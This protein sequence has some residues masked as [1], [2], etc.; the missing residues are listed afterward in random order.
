MPEIQI[1]L[2]KGQGKSPK[3]ADYVDLLP[4]NIVPIVGDAEGA[5]G[6]FRFWP[7]ITKIADVD[8]VSRGSH[9]NTVKDGVYRVMGNKLY[10]G[11]EVVGDVAGVGRVS[12][13]H[14]RTSQAV[15]VGGKLKLYRY[16]G[17][18]KTVSNWPA[19]EIFPGETKSIQTTQHSNSGDTL[20]ITAS[21]ETGELTLTVTP[22][23]GN[24]RSGE[25]ISITEG[26]WK[27]GGSESQVAPAAGIPYIT[28]LKVSGTKFAGATLLV[29]YTFNPNPVTPGSPTSAEEM[30]ISEL[31]WVQVTRDAEIPNPQYEIL[32]TTPILDV[33]R[34]RGRYYF[35]FAGTDTFMLTHLED[36]SKPDLFGAEYRAESMPDGILAIRDYREFVVVFGSSTIEFFK[37]TTDANNPLTNASSYNVPIGIAGQF[38]VAEFMESFAFITSPARGQVI[39]AVMGQGVY[40]QVSDRNTNKILAGYSKSELAGSFVESLKTEDNQFLI[41][42]LPRHTLIYNASSGLWSIAKT[43]L[44][45]DVHRA[46]DYRNEGDTVTCGD[47]IA[48]F[49]G[50]QDQATSAQYGEDQEI[51]L[52]SPL[53]GMEKSV[54]YDMQITANSGMASQVRRIFVSSTSDGINYGSEEA[55]EFDGPWQWLRRAIKRRVGRIRLRIGFKLRIVGATP[56]TLS[57]FRARVE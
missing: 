54:M 42:H 39:V 57:N 6:Y 22:I 2:V 4:T 38:C 12:M 43:G 48:G 44:G 7:G 31:A 51:I 3:N 9:W 50:R 13:A 46:V 33:C 34:Y 16:D 10:L 29:T 24:N 40:N 27:A 26:V 8:G 32:D 36:E 52:Y 15:V 53:I 20:K 18:V 37:L 35:S 55:I 25:P 23:N 56:C 41:L 45:D 17:E 14:G 30:D 11:D 1:P 21:S 5:A 19:N 28:D 49:L 47:K